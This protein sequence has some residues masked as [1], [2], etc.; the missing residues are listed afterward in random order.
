VTLKSSLI[1]SEFPPAGGS[2]VKELKINE[3]ELFGGDSF[4]VFQNPSDKSDG[5]EYF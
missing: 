4:F 5:K 3:P 1:F 2:G